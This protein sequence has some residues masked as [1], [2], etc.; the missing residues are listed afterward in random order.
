MYDCVVVVC[1]W[2]KGIYLFS[3]FSV[4]ST[5]CE[6]VSP[7]IIATVYPLSVTVYTVQRRLFGGDIGGW[8]HFNGWNGM[9]GMVKNTSNTW[10]QRV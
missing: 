9:N 4:F 1:N 6:S 2:P 10:K 5:V 8:A 3:N 7:I